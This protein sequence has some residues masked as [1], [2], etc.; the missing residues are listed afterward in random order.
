[1]ETKAPNL[2][3]IY[4]ECKHSM[5]RCNRNIMMEFKTGFRVLKMEDLNTEFIDQMGDRF[6]WSFFNGMYVNEYVAL[7]GKDR[8]N[9]DELKFN[10]TNLE[11]LRQVYPHLTT[12][13]R[14]VGN[15]HLAKI[16]RE[17]GYDREKLALQVTE[18]EPGFRKEFGLGGK[19]IRPVL[20]PFPYSGDKT[21]RILTK[22]NLSEV[23]NDLTMFMMDNPEG[24]YTHQNSIVPSHAITETENYNKENCKVTLLGNTEVMLKVGIYDN[25]IHPGDSYIHGDKFEIFYTSGDD[26]IAEIVTLEAKGA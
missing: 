13:A 11:C 5:F 19:L 24:I 4:E 20:A 25:Y 17:V 1:M 9:W 23:D 8:I 14:L 16:L 6:F 21:V 26:T 7:W 12:R 15:I 10:I 18:M 3:E 22:R 2:T